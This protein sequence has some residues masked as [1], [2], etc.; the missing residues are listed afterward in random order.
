MPALLE[1]GWLPIRTKIAGFLCESVV[2]RCA[3]LCSA[4]DK[5]RAS[6]E[7]GR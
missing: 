4:V 6:R 5:Q 2:L 3:L 1:H 7:R